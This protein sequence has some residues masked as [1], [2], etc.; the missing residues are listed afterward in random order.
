MNTGLGE[1]TESNAWFYNEKQS[2]EL[3]IHFDDVEVVKSLS[4]GFSLGFDM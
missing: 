4:P 2:K 3:S 1:G